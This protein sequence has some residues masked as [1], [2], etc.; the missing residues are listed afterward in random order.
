MGWLADDNQSINQSYLISK[1]IHGKNINTTQASQKK[2][3]DHQS[4]LP[5]AGKL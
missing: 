4:W 3:S 2:S 5:I 1:Q